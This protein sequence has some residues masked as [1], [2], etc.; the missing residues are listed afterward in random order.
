MIVITGAS[1]FI[2]RNFI[3]L[4]KEDCLC[5]VRR[6]FK[7]KHKQEIVNFHNKEDIEKHIHKGDI[8]I[9]ILGITTGNKQNIL[10]TNIGITKNIVDIAKNKAKKIIFISSAIT[11][12]ENPGIY[13]E[14]KISAENYIKN[15][16]LDYIL[17]K[18]SI[19]Y[20]KDN[21]MI[22]KLIQIIKKSKFIPVIGNGEYKIAPIYVQDLVRIIE[23]AIKIKGKKEY[24]IAGE[25]IS[26]NN[27]I[28]KIARIYCRNIIKIHMP[29]EIL[30]LFSFIPGFPEKDQ[31]DRITRHPKYNIENIKDF[32]LTLTGLDEGIKE[33]KCQGF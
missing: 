4:I 29:V 21:K 10:R 24:V 19:V 32:K 26:M 5:L 20:G 30:R 18:P 33:L 31:L 28:D 1:G 12:M 8:I 27:L 25:E 6:K 7:T 2:G 17:L 22:G 15:S 9:H 11:E 13:G 14:S 23:K 16:G 3:N